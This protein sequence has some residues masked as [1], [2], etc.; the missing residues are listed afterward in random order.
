M[1]PSGPQ[2]PQRA[3]HLPLDAR[4]LG[5]NYRRQATAHLGHQPV[6][7][8]ARQVLGPASDMNFCTFNPYRAT[9]IGP[10]ADE[11]RCSEQRQFHAI[12]EGPARR[13]ALE[14]GGDPA[15]L[16][17]GK[18]DGRPARH[19]RRRGQDDP[20]MRGIDPQRRASRA[21]TAHER[22]RQAGACMID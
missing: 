22:H 10:V 12:D 9:L 16:R 15:G 5:V 8:P 1:P 20:P 13:Q 11:M 19:A 21:G 4:G 3:R 7:Q 2:L 17:L 14:A 6:A 18:A